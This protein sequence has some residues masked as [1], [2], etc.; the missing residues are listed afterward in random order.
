MSSLR[1]M[2]IHSNDDDFEINCYLEIVEYLKNNQIN[3]NEREIWMNHSLIELMRFLDRTRNRELVSN[4]IILLLSLCEDKSL[5]IY[6]D[7]GVIVDQ[8]T[9]NDKTLLIEK[10]MDEFLPN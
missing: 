6:S 9:D 4:A 1:K 8:I 3:N 5:D 7:H 10:L 2:K